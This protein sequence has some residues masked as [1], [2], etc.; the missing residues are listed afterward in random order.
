MSLMGRVKLADRS[1]GRFS[2]PSSCTQQRR[3]HR[4]RASPVITTW[5]SAGVSS[6]ARA[7][8]SRTSSITSTTLAV[9]AEVVRPPRRRPPGRVPRGLSGRQHT[10]RAAST[11]AERLEHL[12]R[13]LLAH[14]ARRRACAASRRTRR[15]A[16]H[17]ARARRRRCARRRAARAAGD[18]RPRAGPACCTARERVG[19]ELVVERA[20][21]ER[22]ARR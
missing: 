17:A 19:D 2:P 22:L 6:M 20:T 7:T 3:L 15:R 9:D 18:R 4:R 5:P 13:L 12:V 14:A 1:R 21:E 10:S 11:R 8:A 16:R